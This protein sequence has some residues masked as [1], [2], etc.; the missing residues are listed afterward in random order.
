MILVTGSNGQLGSELR[1]LL[2][3]DEAIFLTRDNGDITSKTSM[4][5]V[6]AENS[7]D[8]II[9]CAAYTAVDK[10]EN[11]SDSAYLVN[12]KALDILCSF[13]K[14][15]IHISTDYV[16]S[17]E[18]CRPYV[19]TDKVAP[20]GVYG[21]SKLKGEE[22]VRA[23]ATSGAVIRTSWVYSTFG[24]N[25]VKTMLRLGRERDELGVVAD[26]IGTPTYAKDL[27][28]AI[29]KLKNFLKEGKVETYHFSNLGVCSWY[30]FAKEIFDITGTKVKLK[31][32]NTDE[33]PTPAKRPHY[34]V[35]SKNKI[36]TECDLEI[37]HWKDALKE[38][39]GNL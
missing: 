1:T 20:Q 24:N 2:S 13:D 26:Q 4:Q 33:Y 6:F 34:S 27:A 8:L 22:V 39:V 37:P 23:K 16:F 35:M 30:D 38:M 21:D 17:G 29:I 31:P 15:I 10:A 19:E 5:K 7:I 3:S 28:K 18:G 14:P 11:D 9:N 32:I 25:F 12:E 36:M